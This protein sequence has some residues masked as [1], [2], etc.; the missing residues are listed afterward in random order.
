MVYVL[1]KHEIPLTPCSQKLAARLLLERGWAVVDKMAPFTIRWKDR[2]GQDSVLQLI[3]LKLDPA[4]NTTARLLQRAN[5]W[6]YGKGVCRAP[7]P[8]V[9][10]GACARQ[11]R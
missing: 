10:T 4:S 11:F 5:G 6:H 2:R 1:D 8:P 3:D 9:N 7:S